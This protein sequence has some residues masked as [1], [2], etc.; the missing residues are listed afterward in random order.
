MSFTREELE[1]VKIVQNCSGFGVG[2]TQSQWPWYGELFDGWERNLSVLHDALLRLAIAH[3][4]RAHLAL[5]EGWEAD[6]G[7]PFGS[8]IPAIDSFNL[9]CDGFYKYQISA[10]RR[11]SVY[12]SCN[13][14]IPQKFDAALARARK[15][16]AA[17]KRIEVKT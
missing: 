12:A 5:G 4:E 16:A 15:I 13:G 17:W 7:L 10:L 2:T 9:S 14:P 6:R 8:G 1:A 3:P 11:G